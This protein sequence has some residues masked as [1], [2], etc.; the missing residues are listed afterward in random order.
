MDHFGASFIA[1]VL[2]IAELIAIGWIYGVDR[3]CKDVEFML[4]HRPNLYWRLCWRWVTP[5][6]MTAILIYNLV[7]LQ[8]LT[9]QGYV[10]PTIA[11]GKLF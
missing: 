3:L 8:P 5:L 10:Y 7:T 4:G 9:Y 1:L 6:L 2:A 11:Y